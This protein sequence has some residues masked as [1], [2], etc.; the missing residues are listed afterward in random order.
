M[1]FD[2]IIVGGGPVGLMTASELALAGVRACIVERLT[3]PSPHSKALTLHPRSIEILEM[4]GL[5]ER[6]KERG[7]PLPHGHFAGLDTALD[8][9]ELDTRTDYTLFL[10]QT[11][12]EELLEEHARSSGVS[13]LRGHD[14]LAVR[15]ND[16]HAELVVQGPDGISFLT[17]AYIVGADGAGSTVRKQAG[18]AFHGSDASLTAVLGD[19]A[20]QSP[21]NSSFYTHINEEGAV[22]IVPLSPGVYRV[23]IVSP[24]KPQRLLH[25]AV[26]L[27]EIQKGLVQICGTDFGAGNPVWMSRFGNASRLA[28]HYRSKRIF[29][30]GDAAHIH[31][32]AGG[33]G[34]NVRLQDAMNLGWKLASAVKGRASDWLLDSYHT[35]RNP[36]GKE[37]L[38]NT[39]IQTKL[40]DFT[41]SGLYLRELLS[42]ILTFPEVNRYLAEQIAALSVN[43]PSD[44]MSPQHQLNGKRLPDLDITLKDGSAKRLYSFLHSGHFLYIAFEDDDPM[45]IPC[46]PHLK[47]VIAKA[48]LNRPEWDDVKSVLIRPDGH[49]A[50]A[51]SKA[52]QHPKHLISEGIRRWY[53]NVPMPSL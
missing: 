20:L 52:H 48:V 28:E 6:F 23:L 2:V 15:Q 33:Q 1:D 27:E 50:W 5:F 9:S 19:V 7:K 49:V 29:L 22:V 11:D 18:I 43:Y 24:H 53:E 17:A 13:I 36:V 38:R 16:E 39:Q 44:E 10:P 30:A 31:F 14:V 40:F 51:V 32:P 8:F 25:E 34:L 42:D 35:E 3:Q 47:T 26:T 37:L 12:T 41:R 4:R 21:P 46:L 45:Q